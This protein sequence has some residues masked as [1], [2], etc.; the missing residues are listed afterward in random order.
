MHN[1][2]WTAAVLLAATG[3]A[4]ALVASR[5]KEDMTPASLKHRV[6]VTFDDG[7]TNLFGPG[8]YAFAS[9]FVDRQHI[10]FINIPDGMQVVLHASSGIKKQMHKGLHRNPPN[11]GV[12]QVFRYSQQWRQFTIQ[13]DVAECM[14]RKGRWLWKPAQ[15]ACVSLD[16]QQCIQGKGVWDWKIPVCRCM[17]ATWDPKLLKCTENPTA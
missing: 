8:T 6:L 10:R 11:P 15:R 5:R 12:L 1:N 2:Q 9:P 17:N 4:V 13:P 14:Q 3:L 7:T 16:Q